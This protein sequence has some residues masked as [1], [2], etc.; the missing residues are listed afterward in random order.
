MFDSSGLFSTIV[1]AIGGAAVTAAV[2][3]A[4]VMS[5][6]PSSPPPPLYMLSD[7]ENELER[8]VEEANKKNIAL[9]ME[10]VK[11]MMGH[12]ELE[13]VEKHI[14][15]DMWLFPWE[16]FAESCVRSA[17]NVPDDVSQF[18]PSPWNRTPFAFLGD[19]FD[20]PEGIY[21][22]IRNGLVNHVYRMPSPLSASD[23]VIFPAGPFH[24]NGRVSPVLPVVPKQ[25]DSPRPKNPTNSNTPGTA[26]PDAPGTVFAATP[27]APGTATPDGPPENTL[28]TEN[29]SGSTED[30]DGED[31]SVYP[32]VGPLP[33][34]GITHR[35]WPLT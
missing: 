34:A 6:K 12:H 7:R 33:P 27:D 23:N 24:T 11:E 21:T 8:K 35:Q 1:G 22:T 14:R 5:D 26:T 9:A 20:N 17:E 15:V 31:Q 29:V 13:E 18:M 10:L 3:Y 4:T 25:C 16:T 30:T 19:H 32:T 2:V 28:A